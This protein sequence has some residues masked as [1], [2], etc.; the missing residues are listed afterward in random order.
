MTRIF[1]LVILFGDV[2]WGY[3][4]SLLIPTPITRSVFCIVCVKIYNNI[5]N[6]TTILVLIKQFLILFY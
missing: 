5:L 2:V 6:N 4:V 3:I 1:W